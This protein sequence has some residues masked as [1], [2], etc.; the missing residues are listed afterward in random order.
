MINNNSST[1][2]NDDFVFI[3]PSEVIE[4]IY[5]P[6]FIYFMKV[7][8]IFQHE[9]RR[10][11]VNKGRDIHNLKLVRNKDYLRKRIGAIDKNIDVYLTSR[12]LH[13]V[14]KIDEVLFLNDGSAAPLDYKFAFWDDRIFKTHKIQQTL[15][16][17]L[18]EEIYGKKVNKAYLVYV[19]S[20]NKLI[21]FEITCELKS[22]AI[23]IIDD[24]FQVIQYN[25][26][27]VST[28]SKSKCNDCTYKNLCSF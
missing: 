9:H 7:L 6:R 21:D 12:N 20:K 2:Y 1:N 19:R 5:C 27:P 23:K 24:I 25:Y 18:I 26:F 17:L 15:Y 10:K 8:N 14:G 11:L 13:L 28:K 3:T 4:Y 16:A 22:K